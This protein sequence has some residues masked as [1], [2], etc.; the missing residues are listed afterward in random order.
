MDVRR[1]SLGHSSNWD[2]GQPSQRYLEVHKGTT[3][4][5]L[6]VPWTEECWRIPVLQ[7]GSRIPHGTPS[8]S[9]WKLPLVLKSVYDICHETFL[10]MH[11]SGISFYG[12]LLWSYQS[13]LL[14]VLWS[15]FI[16]S[17]VQQHISSTAYKNKRRYNTNYNTINC[18]FLSSQTNAVLTTEAASTWSHS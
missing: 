15:V 18:F 7:K 1:C 16:I 8:Q 4:H 6:S 11:L 9:G 2:P 13:S 14:G 10:I 5:G 12:K 17:E 3:G